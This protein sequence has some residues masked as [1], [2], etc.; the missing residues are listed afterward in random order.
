MNK[1]SVFFGQFFDEKS[2]FGRHGNDFDKKKL[3]EK[4]SVKNREK[5]PIFRQK[6][7]KI[8]YFPEKNPI[9]PKFGVNYILGH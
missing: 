5:S 1:K 4:K 3:E 9:F 7:G 6:I 2:V 8:Q